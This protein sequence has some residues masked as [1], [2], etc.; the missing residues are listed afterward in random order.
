ML[1]WSGTKT[2]FI[3]FSESGFGQYSPFHCGN[4]FFSIRFLLCNAA[5]GKFCVKL[6]NFI[7]DDFC[8]DLNGMNTLLKK[9]NFNCRR[10]E[11][12]VDIGQVISGKLSAIT[13]YRIENSLANP[14]L[15]IHFIIC[16]KKPFTHACCC[17]MIASYYFYFVGVEGLDTKVVSLSIPFSSIFVPNAL[18][19][20]RMLLHL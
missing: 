6:T 7:F 4:N 8:F 19:A 15:P 17:S 12:I 9:G 10:K 13:H 14:F 20:G 18:Q 5:I 16:P 2:H 1:Q 11:I 3:P